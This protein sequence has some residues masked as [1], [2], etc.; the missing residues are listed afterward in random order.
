TTDGKGVYVVFGTGDI[1]GIDY[2]GE[3][4]WA[5]NLGSPANHY[6]HGSS[7][8]LHRNT[9]LVQFDQNT[10]GHLI[11]LNTETG[12]Q[13]YDRARDI[14]ISWASPILINSES[15]SEVV[16]SAN[17]FVISY[18]PATGNELWRFKCMYGEI[19]PSLAFSNGVVFACNDYA[20]LVA[21]KHG[22]IPELLWETD[23][24]LSEISSPVANKD[25][26]I[27]AASFGTV[28]CFDSNT[29]ERHWYYDADD[30]FYS[31][32]I[33]ANGLIYLMDVDGLMHVI[34]ADKTLEIIGKNPL[35]EKSSTT[36]AFYEDKL[37]VRGENH[38]FCIGKQD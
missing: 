19:G 3:R 12:E 2:E 23:E 26:V 30:G 32:P 4:L 21:I 14:E 38:L 35:G 22:E 18:D 31:S 11:G 13:K 33:I 15:R 36:P 1:A 25:I 24:D 17:P 7:L 37:F 5:K 34:K 9:L 8:A 20:S 28:S 6:G 29:G 16:L 27:M 10:G